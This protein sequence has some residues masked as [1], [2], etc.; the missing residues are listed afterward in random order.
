[1]TLFQEACTHLLNALAAWRSGEITT[2]QFLGFI[3][4]PIKDILLGEK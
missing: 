3:R 1:M 2:E 4:I